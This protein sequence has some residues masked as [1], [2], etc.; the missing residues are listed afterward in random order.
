MTSP[1]VNRYILS[2][3]LRA[4]REAAKVS[5]NEVATI[6]GCS[7]GKVTYIETGRN[8]LGKTELEILLQRLG[9]EHELATLDDLR[10]NASKRGWWSA[11]RL[12][13]G[14]ATYVGLED[15]AMSVRNFETVLIPGPLQTEDYT[16]MLYEQRGEI[17]EPA[18]VKRVQVR[19]QR[20]RRLVG[21]EPLRLAA[22]MCTS[23]LEH[24][25]TLP[26]RGARQFERIIELSERP[27]VEIRIL[28]FGIH[29]G[30]QGPYTLL[31]FPHGLL[32]DI[33]WQE[34]AMGGQVIDDGPSVVAL[35]KLYDK[36]RD[37]A[38]KPDASRA[39]VADLL[40]PLEGRKYP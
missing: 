37:Q 12:P 30:M 35:S 32:P 6:L 7:P 38:L 29:P 9:A 8:V 5:R 16:R 31:S 21:P 33:A 10:L 23:A 13:E 26:D 2:R 22:V 4:L 15:G 3:R 36:I 20:Q 40:S 25:R 19:A 24:C 27:N 39:L 14:L 1:T 28:P 34:Y 17:A 11:A 18:I